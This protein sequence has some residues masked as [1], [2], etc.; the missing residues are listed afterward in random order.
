MSNNVSNPGPLA[1]RNDFPPVATAEW[2]AAVQRDLK[3]ADYEKKLVWR[4]EEGIAVRP[5]YRQEDLSGL[6]EQFQAPPGQFPFVRGSG[7]AWKTEED[8]RPAA[9]AVRAD[10]YHEAGANA[11][12]EIAFALAEGV[13]RLEHRAEQQ[14]VDE[15]ARGLEFVFAIGPYYFI[16]IAKLRAA[17]MLWAQVVSAFGPTDADAARMRIHARTALRNKSACDPYINLLRVTTEALSA[18]V[19]GCD[20]LYVEAFGFSPHLAMNV[21]RILREESHLGAVADP[22]AGSYYVEAITDALAREAWKLYQQVEA[23]GGHAI[24]LASGSLENAIARSRDAMQKAVN[25]R[26]RTLVGVNNY[27]D[28]GGPVQ[29]IAVPAGLDGSPYPVLRLAAPFEKVRERTARHARETGHTPRT[30]LLQRGDGKMRRARANFA[31]NFFGC[32]GF[33]IVVREDHA[34]MDADL[35]VLCSSDAEYLA[36]AQEICPQMTVPVL[37]AGN[38]AGQIEALKAAGVQGF[39]HMQSDA[40][41][42]LTAWQDRLGMGK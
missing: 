6:E 2:E 16:E 31:L 4:T 8:A 39:I 29:E 33:E 40:V 15:A 9:G 18:I 36:L 41:E 42:T 27:P 23:E 25:S 12:Q 13:E 5:Y 21:Q 14:S 32:A 28:P 22:A 3:G 17:R 37:V 38:P 7:I 35:V 11:V 19:G 10:F 26:R 30:L 24:A 34:G 1:L 20:G